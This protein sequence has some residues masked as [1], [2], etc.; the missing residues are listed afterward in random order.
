M[1]PRVFLSCM[2][3]GV[4]RECMNSW[5]DWNEGANVIWQAN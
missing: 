1:Q 4:R 5:M 2:H 3:S